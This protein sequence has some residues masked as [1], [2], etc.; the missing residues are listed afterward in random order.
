MTGI[1]KI[2][3]IREGKVPPDMRVPLTPKQC[4]L[5][6][7]VYPEVE[8]VVQRS[9]IRAFKDD[10]YA[11]EGIQLVDSLDDCDLILGVKEVNVNDLIPG[12]RFM[13]FSHTI[14][15]QPYNRRLLQ[16]IV[17]KKIQLIDYELLKDKHG[18]R[19]IGFGRYAGIVG[20]YNGFRT[21]GLKHKLFDLKPANQCV[22]RNELENELKKITL[23][24]NTRIVISGYGRVGHGAREIIDL[25]PIKEVSP[26]EYINDSFSEAVFTHLEAED[27]YERRDGGEFSKSEFYSNPEKYRSS[28]N[29]YVSKTDM[30]I[31]CHF[32]SNK[33]DFILKREDLQK[34]SNRI[35]VVADISCD[36]AGPIACTIRSSKIA[37]PIYGYDPISGEEIDFAQENAIA[38]M[39]IDNLPCELPKDAS[40]DFGN[41]L[42]KEVF[43]ALLRNDIHG[44]INGA[45]ETTLDGQLNEPFSYLQD[46][47]DGKE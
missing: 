22:D 13:F 4:A 35:S 1:K 45:S 15:K 2:G 33:S 9:P 16:A 23:P 32:W 41:E 5:I 44:M 29:K 18:K 19:V 17:E 30:Y 11:A 40:E 43:P 36:I 6:K 31:A 12:K 25:L 7:E 47:L 46:Y 8:I 10:E 38:V 26:D 27:Y 28:F 21:F 3:V 14:K 42:I 20:C 39:A 37:D 24:S 34:E